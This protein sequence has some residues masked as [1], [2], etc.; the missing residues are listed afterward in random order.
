[1]VALCVKTSI[2]GTRRLYKM[3][4]NNKIV[5]CFCLM[6]HV[7]LKTQFL[8]NLLFRLGYLYQMTHTF[9]FIAMQQNNFQDILGEK[10]ALT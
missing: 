6:I 1:M 9:Y 3:T 8:I 7:A 2:K 5:C 4:M 10:M